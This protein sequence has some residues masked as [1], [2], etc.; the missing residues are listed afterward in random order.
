MRGEGGG[1]FPAGV[2]R[3]S[4]PESLYNPGGGQSEMR[5]HG[6]PVIL[7]KCSLYEV[8]GS[9]G[10]SLAIEQWCTSFIV[11]NASSISS[12]IYL[13]DFTICR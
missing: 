4:L 13:P 6:V 9:N 11:C 2:D 7:L 3:P 1:N 5:A 10:I 12:F 8:C